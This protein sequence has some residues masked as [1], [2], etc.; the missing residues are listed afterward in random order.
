MIKWEIEGNRF[1]LWVNDDL[2]FNIYMDLL[3][4]DTSYKCLY[5][6]LRENDELLY[7]FLMKQYDE[8]KL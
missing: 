3:N 8:G 6:I 7:L 5:H 1:K 4:F 2:L